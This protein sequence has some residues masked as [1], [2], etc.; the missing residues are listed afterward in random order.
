[1][2]VPR[3]R[4]LRSALD[5]AGEVALRLTLEVS[6]GV[7]AFDGPPL[8]PRDVKDLFLRNFRVRVSTSEAEALIV[9]FTTATGR[10]PPDRVDSIAI[11]HGKFLQ[12]LR[13]LRRE[14]LKKLQGKTYDNKKRGQ[15]SLVCGGGPESSPASNSSSLP[16]LSLCRNH[17]GTIVRGEKTNRRHSIDAD[18]VARALAKVDRAASSYDTRRID[19]LRQADLSRVTSPRTFGGALLARFDVRVDPLEQSE[20]VSL[21]QDEKGTV[22]IERFRTYF[23]GIIE[24][25]SRASENP[26]K[27]AFLP[28]LRA[29]IDSDRSL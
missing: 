14:L 7:K 20:L 25:Y 13:R 1:M 15:R 2:A 16:I 22:D 8:K 4:I 26:K 23:L 18:V 24:E 6:A 10:R 17:S 11:E 21:L 5:K 12:G 29:A 28:P 3:Q 27:G 19:N 9:N